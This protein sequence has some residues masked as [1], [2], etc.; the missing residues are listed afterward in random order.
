[1]TGTREL[2]G[3]RTDLTDPAG[4]SAAHIHAR[5]SSLPTL[6][7]LDPDEVEEAFW[8]GHAL[9]MLYGPA[10]ECGRRRLQG[11]PCDGPPE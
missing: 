11:V 6:K 10:I 3:K 7:E 4:K 1:M 8:L 2:L 9:G 5:I